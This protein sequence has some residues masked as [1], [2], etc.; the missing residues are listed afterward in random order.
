MGIVKL[1]FERGKL[2][3]QNKHMSKMLYLMYQLFNENKSHYNQLN[4]F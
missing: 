2:S 4:I 1:Y 3:L